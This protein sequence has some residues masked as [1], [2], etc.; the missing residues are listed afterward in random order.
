MARNRNSL[1]PSCK[2]VQWQRH[3]HTREEN[4]VKENEGELLM[5][6]KTV[7]ANLLARRLELPLSFSARMG[8]ELMC[9]RA[10]QRR[11]YDAVCDT[12]PR[13]NSMV[14]ITSH[15]FARSTT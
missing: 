13:T 5:R 1:D 3:R 8:C 4:Q 14:S 11:R 10:A 6:Q 9:I 2:D 12:V 7:P 15:G